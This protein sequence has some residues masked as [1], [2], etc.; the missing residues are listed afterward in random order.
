MG[1]RLLWQQLNQ[2]LKIFSRDMV[3][4]LADNMNASR[5]Y[6]IILNQKKNAIAPK[7]TDKA[8]TAVQQQVN[9]T[10]YKPLT[11][12]IMKS[13]DI[14]DNI[15]ALK[16]QMVILINKEHKRQLNI[17]YLIAKLQ[18]LIHR[19]L[20]LTKRAYCRFQYNKYS[21]GQHLILQQLSRQIYQ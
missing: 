1:R 21:T 18:L 19:C 8:K 16:T 10:I 14:A 20:H 17:R 5:D 11:E 13:A 15:G 2:C 9:A 6:L 3:S 12:A 4:F 7:I